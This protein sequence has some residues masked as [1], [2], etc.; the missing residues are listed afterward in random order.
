MNQLFDED[1]VTIAANDPTPA[2]SQPAKSVRLSNANM[3]KN[4]ARYSMAQQQGNCLT[5]VSCA[6]VRTCCR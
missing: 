4:H 3:L 1:T 5:T 2:S 6:S